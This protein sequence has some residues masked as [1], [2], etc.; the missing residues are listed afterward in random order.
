MFTKSLQRISEDA[1]MP[2]RS[3]P[4]FCK[5]AQGIE[6][7]TT[8][9]NKISRIWSSWANVQVFDEYVQK[10]TTDRSRSAW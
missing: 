9:I 8:V 2:I 5:Y 7:Q 3:G 6:Q 10:F 1:G 4:V